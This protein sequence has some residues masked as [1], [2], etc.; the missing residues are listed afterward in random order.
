[1]IGYNIEGYDFKYIQGKTGVLSFW[2]KAYKTGT[3]CISMRN[4]TNDASYATDF[5]INSTA[6]WEKKEILI[7]FDGG[8]IGTWNYTNGSGL[9]IFFVLACGSDRHVSSVDTWENANKLA[10]SN[11][12]NNINSTSNYFRL[13]QVQLEPGTI[14]TPFEFRPTV[15][16]TAMCQRYYMNSY[17]TGQG[18]GYRYGLAGVVCGIDGDTFHTRMRDNPDAA[19]VT[20]PTYNNCADY[21]LVSNTIGWI[22]RVTVT[23]N[24]SVRAYAGLY[25]FDAEIM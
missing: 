20:A 7:V 11:I 14:A 5:T 6:T 8:G 13:A 17:A 25:S 3:Y 21:D 12:D 15:V 23:A 24:G 18:Y 19:I 9:E 2:V 16:E 1:M 10:T 4:S 22:H